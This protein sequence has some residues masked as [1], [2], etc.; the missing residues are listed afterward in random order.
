MGFGCAKAHGF[1]RLIHPLSK[2]PDFP[3]NFLSSRHRII[4]N[5]RKNQSVPQTGENAKFCDRLGLNP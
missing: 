3:Q 1:Y 4:Y 2:Y 5:Y